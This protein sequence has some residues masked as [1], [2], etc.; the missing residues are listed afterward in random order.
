[1]GPAAVSCRVHIAFVDESG[2]LGSV[3]SP[4]RHFILTAVVVRHDRWQAAQA[5]LA[6]L[7]QRLQA[8]YRLHPG[9]EIHAQQFLGGDVRHRGLDIRARFQC[10]HHILRSLRQS[11]SL[12]FVRHAVRKEGLSA[13]EILTAAWQ[14]LAR[15]LVRQAGA[16]DFP[17]G[18]RGWI[19][20]TDHHG[21]QPHRD[22]AMSLFLQSEGQ[23]LLEHPFGRRSHDSDFLQIA[24][25]LAFLTKQSFEPSGYFKIS[26]GRRLI[27]QNNRVF[28]K[29]CRLSKR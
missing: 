15:E 13:P 28:R 27:R 17:C 26:A 12:G 4:T 8:L 20:V 11:G 3:G 7:R 21:D 1:M 10:A 19:L 14:G 16:V 6:A 22:I 23:P 18:G 9:V 25:F 24:D 5:E 29:P 2:D